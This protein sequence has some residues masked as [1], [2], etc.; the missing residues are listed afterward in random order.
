LIVIDLLN[1]IPFSE[2]GTA[3]GL[4]K[5]VVNGISSDEL[6]RAI[7]AFEDKQFRGQRNGY[8]DPDGAT[9]PN[10]RRSVS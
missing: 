8:I 7:S 4:G 10:Q 5:H 9:A 2:G 1:R 3:G 6:Y